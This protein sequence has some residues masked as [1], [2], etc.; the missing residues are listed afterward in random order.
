MPAGERLHRA[1]LPAR[2]TAGRRDEG[3]ERE[4]SSQ[5][6]L[7]GGRTHVLGVERRQRGKMLEEPV[8]QWS[9]CRRQSL[10]NLSPALVPF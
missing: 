6:R 4:Y 2:V 10:G 7:G 1:A 5:P 3:G 8:G 9:R